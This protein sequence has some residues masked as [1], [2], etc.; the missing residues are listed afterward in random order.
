MPGVCCFIEGSG[1]RRPALRAVVLLRIGVGDRCL[2]DVGVVPCARRDIRK[3]QRCLRMGLHIRQVAAAAKH[4]VEDDDRLGAGDGLV[5]AEGAVRVAADPAVGV[6]CGDR[7]IAPTVA[8]VG[9]RHA[10][11]CVHA[12]DPGEN[13]HKFRAADGLAWL[14]GAVAVAGNG[15]D[16]G[17]CAD[18]DRV[19][20]TGRNI[21]EAVAAAVILLVCLLGHELVE[22]LGRLGARK[23]TGRRKG[24]RAAAG[25]ISIVSGRIQQA[26]RLRRLR[27]GAAAVVI[28]AV[29]A[30]VIVTVIAAAV[31]AHLGDVLFQQ[32]HG[33]LERDGAAVVERADDRHNV[34]QVHICR[35]NELGQELRDLIVRE[36]AAR[37]AR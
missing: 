11:G 30:A 4:A 19:P 1:E 26:G 35:G 5:R 28:A 14:E 16:V 2:D 17:Q 36:D 33:L 13:G 7:I 12:I 21:A 23:R 25:N 15:P 24:G 29:I 31:I 20:L 37:D 32:R 6:G 8:H 34:L 3:V 22:Q 10:F 18:C 27:A 9:K